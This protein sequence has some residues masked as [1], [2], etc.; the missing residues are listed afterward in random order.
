[1]EI[2]HLNTRRNVAALG[3]AGA[4]SFSLLWSGAALLDGAWVFGEMTLSELGDPS[5]PADLVFNMGCVLA[6][7]LLGLFAYGMHRLQAGRWLRASSTLLM[8]ASVFLIGVGLFPIHV[9]LLHN[10]F[11]VAFFATVL[12]AIS[13]S[14]AGDWGRGGRG[15]VM[16]AA[17]AVMAL[18]PLL[19]LAF[20]SLPLA[21]AWAA[22][23][24]MAWAVMRSVDLLV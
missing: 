16:A 17:S 11:A 21:E 1:M 7:V 22:I 15:R 2:E 20:A 9:E 18:L 19:L 13:A 24:A 5:R 10:F 6:G 12:A 8:L 14:A 23:L 4:A 3:I